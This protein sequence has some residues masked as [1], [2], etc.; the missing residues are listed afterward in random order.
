[1]ENTEEAITKG[2]SIENGNIRYTRHRENKRKTQ[3]NINRMNGALLQ[4][5][6]G[7]NCL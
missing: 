1:L 4:T 5:T 2:Q 7:K 3:N 6:G